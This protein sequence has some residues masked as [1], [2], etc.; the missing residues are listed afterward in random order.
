M[1]NIE[2]SLEVSNDM[3]TKVLRVFDTSNY[4][5]QDVENYLVEILPASRKNWLTYHVA[6]N[7]SLVLNSSNLK[8]KQVTSEHQLIELPDGVYEIRQSYKPN[9]HTIVKYFHFRNV[10]LRLKFIEKLCQHFARK[11]DLTP[12]QFE[13]ITEQLTLIRH[14]IDASKYEVEIYHNKDQGIDYYNKAVEM[15]KKLDEN[16]CGCL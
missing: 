3:N 1:N 9:I 6:K 4:C 10:T 12:A 15:L 7:F 8:Y 16:G 14:Y 11:C 13:E 2:L 5:D